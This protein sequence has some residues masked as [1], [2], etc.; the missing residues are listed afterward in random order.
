MMWD[1]TVKC[2]PA[3]PTTLLCLHFTSL[4]V[5][6]V[7][8][9]YKGVSLGQLGPEI[10]MWEG[11]VLLQ[12]QLEKPYLLCVAKEYHKKRKANSRSIAE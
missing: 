9:L 7:V 5:Y 3:F 4:V 10:G 8:L 11:L 1:I 12:K 6:F 2:W